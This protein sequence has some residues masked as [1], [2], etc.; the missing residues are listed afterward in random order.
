M[1][2]VLENKENL[3]WRTFGAQY[4]ENW[5]KTANFGEFSTFPQQRSGKRLWK[6]MWKIQIVEIEAILIIAKRVRRNHPQF[7]P[8]FWRAFPLK[9]ESIITS[10]SLVLQ[11]YFRFS[12]VSPGPISTTTTFIL[13]ILSIFLSRPAG[14]DSDFY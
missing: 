12:T 2:E 1:E 6:K 10:K 11:W 14:R 13:S 7:F 3:M 4:V 9:K 8:F 5:S